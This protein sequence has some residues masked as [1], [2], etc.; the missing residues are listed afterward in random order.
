MGKAGKRYADI[1]NSTNT[2][3]FHSVDEAV[4]LVKN[5]AKSKFN[6]TIEISFNLGVDPNQA[7]Q[8]VRGVV[9]FPEGTGRNP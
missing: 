2:Q 1:V 3:A 7:D 6:E 8:M 4:K 9:N 5:N